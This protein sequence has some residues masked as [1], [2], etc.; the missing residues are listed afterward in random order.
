MVVISRQHGR[1]ATSG[2]GADLVLAQIGTVRD[3]QIVRVE[4]Y[5]DREKA[6]GAAGLS[7]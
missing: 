6:L 1:G 5:L 3:G 2:A 7:K 4:N